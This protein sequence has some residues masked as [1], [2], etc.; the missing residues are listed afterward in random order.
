MKLRKVG[1]NFAIVE[2]GGKYIAVDENRQQLYPGALRNSYSHAVRDLYDF[3]LEHGSKPTK[4]IMW[5]MSLV[6]EGVLR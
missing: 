5:L 1:R 3:E 2:D 6:D 4:E